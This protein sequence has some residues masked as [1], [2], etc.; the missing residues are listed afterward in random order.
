[1]LVKRKNIGELQHLISS[2]KKAADRGQD[3]LVFKTSTSYTT[4]LDILVGGGF[5]KA[6]YIA[7]SVLVIRFKA[8]TQMHKLK[9]FTF[10]GKVNRLGRKGSI[11]LYDLLKLQRR[12]G[13]TAY[14]ILST[15]RGILT[16]FDAIYHQLGGKILFRIA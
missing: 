3:S 8:Y 13:G 11:S 2:I 12:E 9:A 7:S 4:I 6:Y 1:M 5:I 14:Y 15:D 16:S 10:L